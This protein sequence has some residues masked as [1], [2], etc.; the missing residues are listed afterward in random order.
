M[1]L[2]TISLILI[3]YFIKLHCVLCQRDIKPSDLSTS[4]DSQRIRRLK[5]EL[6]NNIVEGP[7]GKKGPRGPPGPTGPPG[8]QGERGPP[9]EQGPPGPP[10]P[11]GPKR[12]DRR[13][14]E[15]PVLVGIAVGALFACSLALVFFLLS[16][17][18]VILRSSND[19]EEE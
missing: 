14:F 6:A 3:I 8:L 5:R 9:G 16:A 13:N 18:R 4:Y 17:T 10:G 15:K 7:Q 19:A 1:Q 11:P 2:E 12:K